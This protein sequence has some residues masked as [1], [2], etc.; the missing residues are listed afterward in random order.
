MMSSQSQVFGS[1]SSTQII[2]QVARHS[3]EGTDGYFKSISVG[4]KYNQLEPTNVSY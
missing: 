4:L 2:Y 3:G 1:P